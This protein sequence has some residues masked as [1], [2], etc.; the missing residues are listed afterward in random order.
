MR[1]RIVDLLK[2]TNFITPLS[3]PSVQHSRVIFTFIIT[4]IW[5]KPYGFS[6]EST[7]VADDSESSRCPDG[8]HPSTSGD[9]E[10]VASDNNRNDE[11]SLSN[12]EEFNFGDS[13]GIED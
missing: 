8:F 13:E 2:P 3:F 12:E 9:C 10:R 1:K 5:F 6:P 11:S 4:T 7:P